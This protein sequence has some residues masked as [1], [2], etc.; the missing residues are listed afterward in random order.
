MGI[1]IEST[2]KNCVRL[3]WKSLEQSLAHRECWINVSYIK[4]DGDAIHQDKEHERFQ[5]SRKK[6]PVLDIL[7]GSAGGISSRQLIIWTKAQRGVLRVRC[8]FR[9]GGGKGSFEQG[10]ADMQKRALRG[11]HVGEMWR[12]EAP[13]EPWHSRDKGKKRLRRSSH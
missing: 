3:T 10:L 4:G 8:Y 7:T 2:S 9:K 11:E 12:K 13:G 1:T 5:G 6:S